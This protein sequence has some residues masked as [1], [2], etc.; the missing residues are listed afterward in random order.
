MM[1]MMDVCDDTAVPSPGRAGR[2][3]CYHGKDQTRAMQG[4][5]DGS[6]EHVGD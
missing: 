1:A 5:R 2:W 6:F 4:S 3:A